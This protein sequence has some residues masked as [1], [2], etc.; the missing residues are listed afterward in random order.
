[1]DRDW[2]GLRRKSGIV[3]P[4]ILRY[5]RRNALRRVV[6]EGEPRAREMY[7]VKEASL[8]LVMGGEVGLM[9]RASGMCG[10]SGGWWGGGGG[11]W[12]RHTFSLT[13]LEPTRTGVGSPGAKMESVVGVRR[14]EPED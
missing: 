6:L 12:S 7:V 1:M 4:R 13:R 9:D 8:M 2:G 11:M 14:Q 3:R 5:P 10:D